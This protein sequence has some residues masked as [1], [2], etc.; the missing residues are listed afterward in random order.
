MDNEQR[1]F[2][3]PLCGM[4]ANVEQLDTPQ[5]YE[6]DE[7]IQ[8]FGGKEKLTEEMRIARRRKEGYRGSGPGRM[9]Y[10]KW[11]KA[12]RDLRDLVTRRISQLKDIY[13]E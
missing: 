11:K 13:L 12:T 9:S 8:Q 5:P 1:R 10:T 7:A 4:V 3:C 6:L 2:H